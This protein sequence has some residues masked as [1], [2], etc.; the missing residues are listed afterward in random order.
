MVCVMHLCRWCKRAVGQPTTVWKGQ[1]WGLCCGHSVVCT[2]KLGELW[3]CSSGR[4]CS[5]GFH[6]GAL[7]STAPGTFMS[8]CTEQLHGSLAW[9]GLCRACAKSVVWDHGCTGL[10]LMSSTAM[11]QCVKSVFLHPRDQD[12][13]DQMGAATIVR[14]YVAC[15]CPAPA[16]EKQAPLLPLNWSGGHQG[17]SAT[18]QQYFSRTPLQLGRLGQLHWLYLDCVPG[19]S[20]HWLHCLLFALGHC[21]AQKAPSHKAWNPPSAI[22]AEVSQDAR[23]EGPQCSGWPRP[24]HWTC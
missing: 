15:H 24:L 4:A 2:E 9:S 22:A 12:G 8:L 5:P 13:G 14:S 11:R 7:A 20:G 19:P 10:R 21:M 17:G 16:P 6:H 23:D 18:H 3:G 1:S